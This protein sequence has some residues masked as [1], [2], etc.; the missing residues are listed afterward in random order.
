M[1][2]LYLEKPTLSIKPL[3][4]EAYLKNGSAL[5]LP[6]YAC[7]ITSNWS[8]ADTVQVLVSR[9]HITGNITGS[10]FLLDLRCAGVKDSF[11]FFNEPEEYFEDVL[12]TY[13]ARHGLRME[14][15]NYVLAHNVIYSALDFA[16]TFGIEPD[17]S[18]VLTEMILEGDT[19]KVEYMDIPCGKNGKPHLS[20]FEL[21][22]RSSCY[23]SQ[24]E[25]NA[26][27]GNF[28]FELGAV[29]DLAPYELN[30]AED[31]DDTSFADVDSWNRKD[32]EEFINLGNFEKLA[33]D[34][35]VTAYI[36]HKGIIQP[37]SLRRRIDLDELRARL[38]WGINYKPVRLRS[39]YGNDLADNEEIRE[40][41]LMGMAHIQR[42][43]TIIIPDLFNHRFDL[44]ALF[45]ER[46]AFQLSEFL[47]F[48]S[49]LCVY[50]LETKDHLMAEI[51][52]TVIREWLPE[53]APDFTN[54]TLNLCDLNM[55]NQV[56][57]RLETASQSNLDQRALIDLL[58]G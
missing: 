51:Y 10:L 29:H 43:L 3:S 18:F 20:V 6:F 42:K 22:N 2:K 7:Y 25:K 13:S 54:E 31:H 9:Q 35:E 27:Q 40:L 4:E 58:I 45:P 37:E 55:L 21:D 30:S 1:P 8:N 16:G 33:D 50:F 15:C 12:A 38:T 47:D 36:Y 5:K 32:W 17:K 28:G 49:I 41:L 48:Y 19:E 23:L 11:Y 56:A 44:H 53:L 52:A 24:L 14:E 34:I 39:I 57:Q 26:G 46:R